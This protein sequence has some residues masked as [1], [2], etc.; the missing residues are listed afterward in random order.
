MKFDLEEVK[1]LWHYKNKRGRGSEGVIEP[2]NPLLFY[3][4]KQRISEKNKPKFMV[5][6]ARTSRM[7][8]AS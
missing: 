7:P 8:C 6:P 3:F 1:C 5:I 4:I 2:K